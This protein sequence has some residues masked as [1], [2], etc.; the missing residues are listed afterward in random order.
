MIKITIVP[1][2]FEMHERQAIAA[3][4]VARQ[5]AREYVP[6]HI[7]GGHYAIWHNGKLLQPGEDP[8]VE[9]GEHLFVACAPSGPLVPI[10]PYLIGAFFISVV[11]GAIINRLL[12]K[13]PQDQDPL[14]SSNY[15]YYGFRNAYRPEGDAIPVVYGTMR[16]APPCINQSVFGQ[17]NLG[18]IDQTA[19]TS[20][21]ERLASMYV[22]SHGPIEGVG[23]YK[24]DVF[25]L[26]DW[27]ALTQFSGNVNDNIG[28]QINGVDGK[29]VPCS[30]QWRTGGQT[31]DPILGT[32]GAAGIDAADP[33]TVY[34]LDFDIV[35][36]TENISESDKAEGV[37]TYA[38]RIIE[39]NSDQYISQFLST[40]ADLALVQVLFKRGLYQGAGDGSPDPFTATVRVQYWKTDATGTATNDVVVLPAFVITGD[41]PGMFSQELA[42]ELTDA[43][44]Y[45]AAEN[46]GYVYCN[47]DANAALRLQGN[48]G[49]DKVRPG[50]GNYDPNL[51][52]TFGCF[53]SINS[54]PNTRNSWLMSWAS[55][56]NDLSIMSNAEGF[57]HLDSPRLWGNGSSFFGVRISRDDDN[58]IGNGG[59]KLYVC[60]VSYEDG[61]V[62]NET[63]RATA[64][65]WRSSSPIGSVASNSSGWPGI[66]PTKHLVLAYDQS[67]WSPSGGE[68]TMRLYI[69]GVEV[70]IQL[71]EQGNSFSSSAS[72]N[73]N[74]NQPGFLWNYLSTVG[75]S[76]P[77]A[78]AP[79]MFRTNS[80][81]TNRLRIGQ[82]G[83]EIGT[84]F[85][86]ESQ[87]E[88]A[89]YLLYDGLIG[90]DFAGVG[91]W[92]YTAFRTRDAFGRNTYSVANM[93]SD[94]QHAPN[95]RI[96]CPFVSTDVVAT[97]F[98][99]NYAFPDATSEADGA[100]R[101]LSTATS[102][103]T[104]NGPVFDVA[105]QADPE[106]GYYVIEVFKQSPTFESS[107][108]TDKATIDS[109][110]TF[111]NLDL[112]Y[113]NVA[114]IANS[115]T[116]T[117]Q[118]NTNTPNVTLIVHGRRVKIW[119]GIDEET[120]TFT[121]AW[122]DNPA[123]IALDLLTNKD[124][125][126][127]D[128]VSPTGTYENIA[129]RSFFEWAKFCDEGVP[130]AFG[131]LDFFGLATG[132]G[133][134]PNGDTYYSA[135]LY[136]GI[137]NTSD[138]IEQLVPASWRV[139]KYMSI[140]SIVGGGLDPA[141]VTA[142]D[143]ELGMN[144]ASNRLL[145]KSITPQSSETGFHGYTSYVEVELRWNR[146]AA[147][148]TPIWPDGVAQGDSF[149]D[150]DFSGLTS[151]G[152]ASQYE[153]RCRFDGVIGEKDRPA[154][155]A[156]IDVFQTGRAMP[157]RI[158]RRYLPVWDRPRD[159][160][161]MIGMASMVPGT[162][163]ISYLSPEENPNSIEVEILDEDLGYQRST[164]LVDHDSIQNPTGFAQVRKER[165]KRQ[166]I[167]RRSQA[168]RDAYYR[169]NRYNLQT[170]AMKFR[171]GPDA[172]HLM[173]GDRILVSHDVPDFGTS[174]RL[175]G[176]YTA[177][178]IFPSNGDIS[179]SWS[180][181]GGSAAVSA[182]SLLVADSTT[183]PLTGY[184]GTVLAYSPPTAIGANGWTTGGSLL[185]SG[186]NRHARWAQQHVAVSDGLY[187]YPGNEGAVLGPLDRI[188]D[189]EQVKEFSVY[190][191]QPTYNAASSILLNIY[192]FCDEEGYVRATHGVRFDW[193][194]SGVLAF[195]AYVGGYNGDHG[196]GT[197]SPY[198][199]S[200]SVTAV[201]DDGWY[202]AAIF[203][204]NGDTANGGAGADGV[205]DYVQA[206][207]YFNYD[208]GTT[209]TF[210]PS[211][212]GRG[213][214][215]LQYGDPLYLSGTTSGGTSAWSLVN[216]GVGSNEIQQ[217]TAS[218]PPFY[219][220]DVGGL[221]GSR[222]YVVNI[223]NDQVTNRPAIQQTVALA[224]DW[225]GGS[226]AGDMTDEAVCCTFFV[227]VAAD[228]AAS[229][230]TVYLK[231]ATDAS[232]DASGWPSGNHVTWTITPTG[233]GTA[234][235]S[236]NETGGQT[237]TELNTS[238][239]AVQLTDSTTDADW[240]Q[241][242]AAFKN[243]AD[244]ANLY[245]HLG[246]AGNTG[247][248][249]SIDV[250][251]LRVHG[252]GGT[253]ASTDYVSPYPHRG[254]LVFGAQYKPNSTG[255]VATFQ[256][257][258]T[259]QL[260]RAVTLEAGESYEV[261][262]RDS[263]SVDTTV[264]G[265]RIA[266][267]LVDASEVPTT[268][269]TTKAART[270]IKVGTVEG[271]TPSSGDLYSFGKVNSAVEDMVVTEVSLEPGSLE[272]EVD[273]IEYNADI[274]NDTEFGTL[275]DTT[276]TPLL[277]SSSGGNDALYGVGSQGTA[278]SPFRVQAL[279]R[280]Y[281]TPNGT[282]RA[283]I[284]ISLMP[285]R[286]AF[287][288]KEVRLYLSQILATGEES[289]PKLITTLPYG[290]QQYRHEEGSMPTD[291]TLRVRAQIVGWRGAARSVLG[292]PFADVDGVTVTPLPAAP[293]V[294]LDV[295]G[296]AEMYQ[297]A[298]GEDTRIAGMEGRIGGWII[299][300]PAFSADPE[301]ETVLSQQVTISATNSA[302]E[303]NFPL[304]T[305]AFL[306]TGFYGKAQVTTD[307]TV[308]FQDGSDTVDDVTEDDYTNRLA[309]PLDIVTGGG[310]L[311]WSGSSSSLGPVY[312]PLQNNIDVSKSYTTGTNLA[313]R[314]FVTAQIQGYQV[315]PETLA[316][317][318][319]T[320]GSQE[321]K[322]W[323]LEGPMDDRDSAT[324]NA[325]VEIEWR[326]TSGDAST[327]SSKSW[328]PF[329]NQEVF[330][331]FAQ[332]RL[333]WTRP[334]T[335]YNVRLQR[336]VVRVYVPPLF[337]PSDVDGGTF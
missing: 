94:E 271:W 154:W 209:A 319:F 113:P 128:I 167:T 178:N 171:V 16:V 327:I 192:R 191:K 155:D 321:A 186:Y 58:V 284:D 15:S 161:A 33:A 261:Y 241:V 146:I 317:M 234:T 134:E 122:S 121:T 170:K 336:F 305:R 57:W 48:A 132:T 126:L 304:V 200:Y 216:S 153:E 252:A 83:D 201:G 118:V 143:D 269:T 72:F 256:T 286:G 237:L 207:L 189:S 129:L 54:L 112:Q 107:A 168:I 306:A 204:D 322:R 248:T 332:F 63:N 68:G 98:Y 149:F 12:P 224:T 309:L 267:A 279:A 151:L 310:N 175:A 246:V 243:S 299:S 236:K 135:T 293:T 162:F 242:D 131:E 150:D 163:G 225:P 75:A 105:T 80:G 148:S 124:Y 300:T 164:I 180:Q 280:P 231:L 229:N 93:A 169:L 29:H 70:P 42:V 239:A 202:R 120:P 17:L 291:R 51:K 32:L 18:F 289:G 184:S 2:V 139:D 174:G 160:V 213:N 275:G 288:Y 294:T 130:D 183:P 314:V 212:T 254:M 37:Y 265:D 1:N 62:P 303:I 41:G 108:K 194:G 103:K 273:C 159:P 251:G 102:V 222:G 82:L 198:G 326:W 260:D 106:A 61:C 211:P 185:D 203:Y 111:E 145:I 44:N 190:V 78:H 56:E 233:S 71:G 142:G 320:L 287:P 27:N 255:S 302:G 147:D 4:Y 266:S 268:G 10:I 67:T 136:F 285:P 88:V 278:G 5:S 89:Q 277:Q 3:P 218:A 97:N 230:R 35:L 138:E 49:L 6:P 219:P 315:R 156:L 76:A 290:V 258:G 22:L 46:N 337:D 40:P 208:S 295:D 262:L 196:S 195:G 259:L 276:I 85:Q 316:D 296:Y 188:D 117:D 69:D 193:N 324:E 173:P 109:I 99:K 245:F 23:S 165:V 101:I 77:Y 43:D 79:I 270:N 36:G 110:T 301:V 238:I 65:W 53:F 104:S 95:L 205:G 25:S 137:E 50:I 144:A 221:A 157:A 14:G 223:K 45:T 20:I 331:R 8:I 59:D 181:N 158:G 283:A 228:N 34:G 38:N 311:Q 253:G 152:K 313:R 206:R 140:T 235:F 282:A 307:D 21:T 84:G 210:Y 227:R 249:A 30:W 281:R 264:G 182:T 9:D 123:W 115:I 31:Q 114:V 334:T 292:S 127:G 86:R 220:S 47:S 250:W 215:L 328:R 24:G 26:A 133:I 64:S 90:G 100:L 298:L 199:L 335:S 13:P 179:A 312:V 92:A 74:G 87:V 52:F 187:P 125:G 11:A 81:S 217:D 177:E 197:S 7:S 257:G 66:Y 244:F 226:G 329:K 176:S 166:G 232:E 274:Y 318:A 119:D 39:P 330:L 73:F 263:D 91:A 141:W 116:A 96:A 247:G 240:Y 55:D 272:R 325:K 214:Q 60:V 297:T 308:A 333:K 28:F 172:L 19:T 323:S